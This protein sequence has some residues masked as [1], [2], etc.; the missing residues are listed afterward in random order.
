MEQQA[1]I[2]AVLMEG[3]V[4]HLMPESDEWTITEK[5]VEILKPFQHA[6]EAMSG[7]K[8]PTVSTI[9]PLLY[10]LVKKTLAIG[11]SDSN[12]VIAVKKAIKSDLQ[13]RYQSAAVQRILNVATYLHSRYK[14]LPFLDELQK[15]RMIDDVKDELLA[16]EIPETTEQEEAPQ[17]SEEP[18]AKKRRVQ[19]PRFLEI[20]LQNRGKL[21]YI[22]TVCQRKWSYTRLK[23]HLS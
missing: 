14:E 18:P 9:K 11:D 20:C 7:E 16:L 22:L 2:A 17:E 10:K 12:T 23:S 3:K 1:A 6:T 13:G 19:F 21:H 5:L 8:Y 4:R 15:L